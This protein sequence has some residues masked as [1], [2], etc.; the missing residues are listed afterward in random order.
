MLWREGVSGGQHGIARDRM[1]ILHHNV[2]ERSIGRGGT[3]TDW[4]LAAGRRGERLRFLLHSQELHDGHALATDAVR[5][6]VRQGLQRGRHVVGV[7]LEALFVEGGQVGLAAGEV[8]VLVAG[9]AVRGGGRG[10]SGAGQAFLFDDGT[11]VGL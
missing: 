2:I 7:V 6:A 9:G 8:F 1:V 3:E 5:V 11:E 4:T 10:R